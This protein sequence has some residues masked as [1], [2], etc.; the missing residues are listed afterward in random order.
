MAP[1]SRTSPS[2]SA[3]PWPSTRLAET[4]HDPPRR[5]PHPPITSARTPCRQN[6]PDVNV[7]VELQISRNA[8]EPRQRIGDRIIPEVWF[9]N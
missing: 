1:P 5:L 9:Q 6:A 2:R 7:T 3:R 4:K 8:D